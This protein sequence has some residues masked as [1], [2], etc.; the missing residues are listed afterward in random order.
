MTSTLPVAIAE[1]RA[2]DPLGA[3]QD[4]EL[5]RGDSRA[6]I[7]VRM[8]RQHEPVPASDVFSDIRRQ[9]EAYQS[10]VGVSAL[11]IGAACLTLTANVIMAA[12][13]ET[14]LR[15]HIAATLDLIKDGPEQLDIVRNE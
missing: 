4:G 11:S 14:L 3:G 5:G 15:D 12:V 1:Q 7:V 2:L 8:H 13:Q 10:A 9:V 6:A